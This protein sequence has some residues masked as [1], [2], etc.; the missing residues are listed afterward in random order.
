MT[1]VLKS[2]QVFLGE[3]LGDINGI[4][5]D[6]NWL[7]ML[8]F[9]DNRFVHNKNNVNFS[10]A[11][12]YTRAGAATYVNS[13]GNEVTVGANIPRLNKDGLL[14]E[15]AANNILINSDNAVSQDVTLTKDILFSYRVIGSGTINITHPNSTIATGAV[16]EGGLGLIQVSADT[17]KAQ[18]TITGANTYAQVSRVYAVPSKDSLIHTTTKAEGR[19]T[20]VAAIKPS[21]LSSLTNFTVVMH[22]SLQDWVRVEGAR[23]T[24]P[25]LDIGFSNGSRISLANVILDRNSP[26]NTPPTQ[27]TRLFFDGVEKYYIESA[28]ISKSLTFAISVTPTSVKVA[29]NGVLTG[30]QSFKASSI[31]D[32]TLGRAQAWI[33][34]SLGLQ[35]SVSHVAIFDK[36]M[37]ASELSSVSKSWI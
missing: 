8:N 22:V 36:A 19:E 18:V 34:T 16:S 31:S 9:A 6:V 26:A 14:V 17:V 11:V 21:L 28:D 10:D 7:T 27:R 25:I 35:G 1:L 3:P 2:N 4:E 5:G 24:Q 30:E 32:F 15:A 33:G 13:I 23:Y 29:K 12:N 20:D 37:S